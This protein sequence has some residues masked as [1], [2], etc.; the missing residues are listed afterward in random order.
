MSTPTAAH[1]VPTP[2]RSRRRWVLLGAFAALLLATP[3]LYLTIASWQ[4]DREL[5]AIYREIEADDPHWRWA[6]LVKQLPAPPP[7]ERNAMVQV[8]KVQ[9]MMK[10]TFS[11][12]FKLR[13][14]GPANAR[15]KDDDEQ[16]LRTAL[17]KLLAPMTL[18]EAR[19]LKDMPESGIS[20][21]P[22]VHP[23]D[24]DFDPLR[25]L[26][27]IRVL[28]HDVILLAHENK[29]DDAADSCLA[30]VHSTHAIGDFPHLM[31]QLVRTAGQLYAV[32]A[33]ERT[34]GQG[35]VDDTR[36]ERLQAAM[37]MEANHNGTYPALRGERAF[38]HEHYVALRDGDIAAAQYIRNTGMDRTLE[39][40]LYHVFPS[41]LLR[42]YSHHLRT[43]N[44]LA[45]AC[46]L[47]DHAQIEA[48]GKIN[49]DRGT[50]NRIWADEFLHGQ[51]MEHHKDHTRVRCAAAALAAERYR[52]KY[53]QWPT[54]I[55]D[56]VKEGLLQAAMTDPY[57]GQPLRFHRTETGMIVYSIGPDKVDNRGKK[58]NIVFEL[59]HPNF[60]AVAAPAEVEAP[61]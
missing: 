40:K 4:R 54:S 17:T 56:L 28:K 57:D 42:G 36:L 10:A 2:K 26:E 13:K 14:P 44:S 32:D 61:K 29:P 50:P 27:V 24:V 35:V 52:L 51:I 22:A 20:I 16:R 18:E 45:A 33:I 3:F 11:N 31:A 38:G 34:L 30:L 43:V 25:F 49:V 15:L 8:F 19:K 46:K 39:G 37:T 6:D 55:A 53:D 48:L 23:K 9:E 1:P 60:R 5:E 12:P 41:L 21:D 59:W 58:G 47:T 7:E